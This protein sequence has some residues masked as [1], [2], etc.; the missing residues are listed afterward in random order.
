MRKIFQ[1]SNSF[2]VIFIVFL[3]FFSF[4]MFLSIPALFDYKKLERNLKDN[5]ESNF[6]FGLKD[7]SEIEYRFFPSPHL[8]I[9]NSN[10]YFEPNLNINIANTK[11]LRIYISIFK[12]YNFK[13][14]KIKKIKINNTN[15][16][17]NYSSLKFY[18]D[19]IN[20]KRSKL[21]SINNSKF[22]YYDKS[23]E[24]I[25][26]SPFQN[27]NYLTNDKTD[28]SKL[29]IKGNIFDTN[30]DFLWSKDFK[31]MFES[32]FK[33]KF[34]QPNLSIENSIDTKDEK[35]NSGKVK[36]SFLSEETDIEYFYNQNEIN[37]KTISNNQFSLNGI[38]D[39]KPF[40]FKIDST[41]KDTKIKNLINNILLTYF[42]YKENIHQNL[43]GELKIKFNNLNNAYFKSGFLDFNFSDSKLK[44]MNNNLSVKNIGS[45]FMKNNLFYENKGEIFFAAELEITVDNNDE[46]FRRFAIPIKKR[47]KFKT[48]FATIEKNIDSDNFMLSNFS[49]D[50]E[51]DFEFNLDNIINSEKDYFDNFQ[52]FRNLIKN[53][54]S[55][56]N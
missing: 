40:Y 44:I 9:K 48:I 33:L 38:I 26:I 54:I 28:Q 41:I 17:F 32:N 46:F 27:L 6:N 29:K 13:Q 2:Y 31:N 7:I 10:I 52:K 5:V 47:K 11:N 18:L 50:Y 49:I 20:N 4:I 51:P 22:F 24:V 21:L 30:F 14:I 53:K 39:L 8:F 15:F 55:K 16:N 3:V 43:N 12:L 36:T 34:R 42:N 23:G 35:Y 56:I 25:I 1:K 37:L 45:I 19:N